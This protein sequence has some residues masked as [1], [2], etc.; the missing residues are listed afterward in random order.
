MQGVLAAVQA[1][2]IAADEGATGIVLHA[3]TAD[4]QYSPPAHWE[5]VQQLV[6][7][8]PGLPVIGNG[9]VFEAADAVQMMRLTG[10]AGGHQQ[11][12]AEQHGPFCALSTPPARVQYQR[13]SCVSYATGPCNVDC[14]CLSSFH[15]GPNTQHVKDE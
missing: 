15:D 7:A 2:V 1:G 3:R 13:N 8:V 5:A 4:Q 11:L 12:H 9:D 14:M 6:Q 10:C